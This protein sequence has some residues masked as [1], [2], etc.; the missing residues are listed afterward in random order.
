M[1]VRHFF[2]EVGTL[3]RLTLRACQRSHPLVRGATSRS[4]PSLIRMPNPVANDISVARHLFSNRNACD[5][6][7]VGYLV[8]GGATWQTLNPQ[9]IAQAALM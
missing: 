6:E 1:L 8:A 5:Q 4:A 7:F 2:I 3:V 9:S